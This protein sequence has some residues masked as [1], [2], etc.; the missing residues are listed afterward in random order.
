MDVVC[1]RAARTNIKLRGPGFCIVVFENPMLLQYD[2][3]SPRKERTVFSSE[4]KQ[5]LE[6]Y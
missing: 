3:S 2:A 5:V 6:G 4:G 1:Q